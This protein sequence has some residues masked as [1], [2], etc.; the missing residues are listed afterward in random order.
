MNI[1]FHIYGTIRVL[2]VQDLI[3]DL[4]GEILY[5]CSNGRICP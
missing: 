1:Q 3:F 2:E 4:M 5:D